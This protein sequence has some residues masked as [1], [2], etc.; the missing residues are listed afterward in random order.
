MYVIGGIHGVGKSTICQQICDDLRLE[1]LS[2]SDLLKW[3]EI[4]KDALN[5]KVKS[6]PAT[7]DRLLAGLENT[8]QSNKSYLLDGHYCLLN[9]IGEI[10]NVPFDTFK[11][12]NPASLNI[13]L[14]DVLE[15]KG[16]LE[17]RDSKQYD[18]D[19]L[20]LMQDKEL[21]YALELSKELPVSGLF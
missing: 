10:V 17:K 7:Q 11:Q 12:I 3:K 6:I 15:I 2:A 13:I 4:N 18:S 20:K 9:S 8:I 19:L 1:Y 5:K 16:R 14:G 21:S